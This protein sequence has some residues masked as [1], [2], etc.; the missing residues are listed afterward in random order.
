V[1]TV[2]CVAAFEMGAILDTTAILPARSAAQVVD[3]KGMGDTRFEPV[4][5]TVGK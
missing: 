3:N 1:E 4:T 5:S 2:N